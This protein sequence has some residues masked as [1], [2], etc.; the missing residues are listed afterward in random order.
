[1]VAAVSGIIMGPSIPGVGYPLYK[2]IREAAI[3]KRVQRVLTIRHA[4]RLR[5]IVEIA[6]DQ[7]VAF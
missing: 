1:V 4:I 5:V 7:P 3:K 2:I 6:D